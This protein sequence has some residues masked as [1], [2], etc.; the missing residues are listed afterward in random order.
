MKTWGSGGIAL[1]FLTLAPD[2]GEWSTSCSGHFF[3]G[4]GAPGTHWIGSWVGCVAG[5]DTLKKGNVLPYW[6]SNPGHPTHNSEG[7]CL[8]KLL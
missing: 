8:I 5:L 6:E 1:S 3:P 4:E 7:V 2:G